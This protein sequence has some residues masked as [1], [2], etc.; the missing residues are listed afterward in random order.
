MRGYERLIAVA[1]EW[2]TAKRAKTYAALL[3]LVALTVMAIDSFVKG[4][5]WFVYKGDFI[6]Y[7]TGGRYFLDGRLNELYDFAAQEV[8][9]SKTLRLGVPHFT[10]FNHPPFTTL[11][12]APFAMAGFEWGL[13]LWMVTGLIA[14]FLAWRMLHRELSALSVYSPLRL[15]LLSF[16]F[17]PTIAW[18]LANQNSAF[19]FLIYT[20]TYIQ[21]RRGRDLSGG[22]VLGCLLYKPQLALTPAF[23][24]LIKGRFRALT[25]FLLMSSLL[26]VLGLL[27][28]PEATLTYMRVLPQIAELPFLPGYP[29]EKMHN[30]YGFSV[31]LL[32]HLTSVRVVETTALLLMIGGL[33]VVAAWWRTTPWQPTR[34]WDL[35]FAFTL[36]LGLLISP[37]LMIYDLMALLLPFAIVCALYP[38]RPQYLLDGGPLLVWTALVWVVVFV[39]TDAASAM[40]QATAAMGIPK[41]AVQVSVPIICGWAVVG[42]AVMLRRRDTP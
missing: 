36:A 19:T 23:I 32:A 39:S 15:S 22:A 28:S 5:L 41:L 14:L 8:F 1:A 24:L 33:L 42:R 17:Y 16:C 38:K 6:L 13:V 3:P 40:L 18:A 21:L 29:I 4:S 2:L 9:Q 7:Y 20:S 10:P 25:G 12:Y 34:Q 30:F 27:L 11:F 35:T 37:H 31:L 26:I